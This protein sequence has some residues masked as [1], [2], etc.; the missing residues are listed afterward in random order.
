MDDP[1]EWYP[2]NFCLIV[3]IRTISSFKTVTNLHFIV[4]YW[5]EPIDEQIFSRLNPRSERPNMAIEVITLKFSA[6]LRCGVV[7]K[8]RE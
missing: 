4:P 7:F 2:R 3:D 1:D 5:F 6:P 8:A